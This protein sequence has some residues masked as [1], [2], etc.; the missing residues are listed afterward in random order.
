MGIEQEPF[1]RYK[2][3]SEKRDDTFTV[4]LNEE[5]RAMFNKVKAIIE[6][7]KDSTA[8]KQM[9]WIGA[10]VLLTPENEYML[11]VIFQNKRKNKRLG[12]PDFE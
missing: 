3:D 1:Q 11:G 2:L 6:Q 4:K 5:E 12:I 10:K 8:M 9:A 7:K